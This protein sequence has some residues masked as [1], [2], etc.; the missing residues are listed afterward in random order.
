MR[1]VTAG[2][3]PLTKSEV[4]S[5]GSIHTTASFRLNFSKGVSGKVTSSG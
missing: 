3:L 1:T 4:P 2:K 5:K